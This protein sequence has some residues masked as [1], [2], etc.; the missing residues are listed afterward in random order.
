MFVCACVP[1]A[2]SI[3]PPRMVVTRQQNQGLEGS[4]CFQGLRLSLSWWVL[5][6]YVRGPGC[7]PQHHIYLG[8]VVHAYNLGI[9][10]D[11]KFR[12][13]YNHILYLSPGIYT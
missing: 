12:V 9:Q 10:E 4:V 11:Q 7:D 1:V 6:S 3:G 2:L 13:I 5:A 8:I